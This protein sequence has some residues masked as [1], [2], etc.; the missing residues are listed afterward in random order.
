[1][2]LQN[3]LN[4]LITDKGSKNIPGQAR[5]ERLASDHIGIQVCTQCPPTE[6]AIIM[7]ATHVQLFL[8]PFLIDFLSLGEITCVF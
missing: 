4:I 8:G 1:M 7:P 3:L 6:Y 5:A 2:R